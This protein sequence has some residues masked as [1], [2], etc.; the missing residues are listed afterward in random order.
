MANEAT[1]IVVEAE[2]TGQPGFSSSQPDHSRQPAEIEI[3]SQPGTETL[4]ETLA[5]MNKSISSIATLLE[6]F[7]TRREPPQGC[8]QQYDVEDEESEPAP[9][10]R[11][12]FDELSTTASD[13]DID[14]LI[15]P[16]G[17][18]AE[19][20][21]PTQTANE[22]DEFIKS[23]EAEFADSVP[24]GPEINQSLANIAK[25]R[26]GITLP[27][28][29]LKPLLEKQAQPENCPAAGDI[30]GLRQERIRPTLKPE[31]AALCSK[32]SQ[33]NVSKHLFGEDLARHVHDDSKKGYRKTDKAFIY[34][35]K[36]R[37]VMPFKS[38]VTH[39]SQAIYMDISYGPTF[40]GGHDIHIA[41]NAGHNYH[42]YARFGQTFLAPNE[43]KEKHTVSA[44][45]LR[46]T[47]DE[48]EVFYFP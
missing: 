46:F 41:D 28:E 18:S 13:Q 44:G 39:D 23:L 32:E 3:T 26:W 42:S 4:R 19:D 16:S 29:K 17:T 47:P 22:P 24:V 20:E 34:S 37:E 31:Y 9:K 30:I 33:D 14:D 43:V 21:S 27:P 40:G 10:R 35:L 1:R 48:V 5:E 36:N 8:T 45:S 15:N 25:K 38:M 2:M 11:R 6:Q 12:D 7:V